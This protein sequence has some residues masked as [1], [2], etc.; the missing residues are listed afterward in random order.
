MLDTLFI[1]AAAPAAADNLGSICPIPNPVVP[2]IGTAACAAAAANL[3]STCPTLYP[4]DAAPGTVSGVVCVGSG[5]V[6]AGLGACP[7]P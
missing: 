1:L 5:G 7:P 2:G 4:V 3:G 6:V